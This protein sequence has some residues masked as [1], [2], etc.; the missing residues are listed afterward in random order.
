M[1][2]KEAFDA[3]VNGK[4][5]R[6]PWNAI[7]RT[8]NSYCCKWL[9]AT[10]PT[11][12][13]FATN[14]FHIVSTTT[15]PKKHVTAFVMEDVGIPIPPDL[16]DVIDTILYWGTCVSGL[17]TSKV[18]HV[19]VHSYL[20]GSEIPNRKKMCFSFIAV[21]LHEH[22]GMP[23]SSTSF[24]DMMCAFFLCYQ[25]A[26]THNKHFHE[27]TLDCQHWHFHTCVPA[28]TPTDAATNVVAPERA[29]ASCASSISSMED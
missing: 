25:S 29:P 3:F 15:L 9:I 20:L 7:K 1:H 22:L 21:L 28:T 13:L 2:S 10:G 18:L 12:S 27:L 14:I 17:W 24:E 23:T 26:F 8:R 6:C 4:G 5:T 11:S 16:D 19:L